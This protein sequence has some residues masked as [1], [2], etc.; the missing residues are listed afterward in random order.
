[1]ERDDRIVG[2]SADWNKPEVRPEPSK[3]EH[4][5]A[6]LSIH[7]FDWA[8]GIGLLHPGIFQVSIGP[9]CLTVTWP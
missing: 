9:L 3:W 5:S 6:M 1:M 8:V 4:Y 2:V 7:P